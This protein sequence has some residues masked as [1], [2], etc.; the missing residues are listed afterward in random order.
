[1]FTRWGSGSS[2][3]VVELSPTRSR[4]VLSAS[5]DTL[6]SEYAEQLDAFV[7]DL[8][9]NR[10]KAL[11]PPAAPLDVHVGGGGFIA[12]DATV[13]KASAT[14]GDEAASGI[15]PAG[16]LVPVTA[17]NLAAFTNLSQAPAWRSQDLFD[18]NDEPETPSTPA[19]G[20]DVFLL[21]E[22]KDARVRKLARAW[23]PTYWDETTGRRRR[24]LLLTWKAACQISVDALVT[25]RP[26]L[27]RVLWTVGW[28]FDADVLAAHKGHGDGHVLALNP[29]DASGRSRYRISDRADRR[30]ILASAVHEV[31]H[32]VHGDHNEDF[33]SLLTGLFAAVD[34]TEAD[35]I[36]RAS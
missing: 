18:N 20:F 33:A 28:T 25:L 30:N 13:T 10:R 5:R 34:Q 27:G 4:E 23:D 15:D 19:L 29:V 24:Q 22:S 6:H 7:T 21:A 11:R 14:P 32:V 8:S 17:G 16:T 31:T 26:D 36:M 12:T 3:I 35:R 2:D 9:Q 1:M